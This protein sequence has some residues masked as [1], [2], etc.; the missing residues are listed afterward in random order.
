M[1]KTTDRREGFPSPWRATYDKDWELKNLGYDYGSNLM[2]RT[3][4]NHMFKNPNVEEFL[5][6]HL[7]PIMVAYINAVKYIKVYYNFAVPKYYDKIN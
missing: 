4:S 2:K 7:Q 3:F 6:K 1:P 5:T